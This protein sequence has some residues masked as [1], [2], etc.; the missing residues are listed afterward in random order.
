MERRVKTLIVDDDFMVA[1][2]L[3]T[4]LS[5]YGEVVTVYDGRQAI[6]AVAVAFNEGKP[7]ALIC[8][9]IFMP[10]MDGNAA[11]QVIKQLNAERQPEATVPTKILMM[12]GRADKAKVMQAL[13]DGCD[14]FIIKPIERHTLFQKLA[15]MGMV[16]VSHK[17]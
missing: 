5:P 11:L 4:L 12:T 14:D 9:D 6:E 10:E 2:Y 13:Q 15:A 17:G 3:Q 8:L 16:I 7:F 1:Q